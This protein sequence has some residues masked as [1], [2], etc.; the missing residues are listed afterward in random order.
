[1]ISD[2]IYKIDDAVTAGFGWKLGPF[3]TWDAI[4]VKEVL[5]KMKE[6]GHEPA[7]WVNKMLA[8]DFHSF[9]KYEDGIKYYYDINNGQYNKVPGT[10]KLIMLDNLSEKSVIWH[11]AGVTIKDI[12]DGIINLEFHTKMNTIGRDILNGINKAIDLAEEKYKALIISNTGDN[13]SAGANV[14]LIFM[15]AIESEMDELD[16]AV[17]AFQN[18]MMRVR[19]SNI[20]VI[21]APHNM[22][23]GGGCELC[24]H[25]DRVITHAEL[26]MGLVEFGA[27]L[28]PGGGGT[29][30]FALRTSED[31]NDGDP[32]VNALKNRFL[33]IGQAKV[34]TSAEQAF[35]LGYL[36]RGRDE[37]I[38]SRKHQ[39]SYAKEIAKDM[40][41]K[42]YVKP[43]KRRDIKV[44]GKEGLGIVYAGADSMN[45]G[46]FITDYE[47]MM[48]EKLGNV[49]CGGELS[50][51]TKVS[52]DHLLN[53]ERKTFLE[54]A[55][56]KKSME[57]ME[58]IVKKGKPVR[59]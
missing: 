29:K 34:S 49:M 44:L 25:A 1:E 2:E 35:E 36:K 37:V 43:N 56:Q 14:G 52:E 55:M 24:M 32:R 27:G 19:Y 8:N 20:P 46:H 18:T 7:D 3:E 50:S 13:F 57:R 30:E 12:S 10:D 45:T 11:N 16:M 58:S 23:L 39:V 53:L 17:R 28:I 21:A 38:L 5:K 54:L 4:G 26:Y 22:V 33:T 40:A 59:N 9:Y 51:P 41:E 42:G 48:S 31:I 15:Y 6:I 47:K